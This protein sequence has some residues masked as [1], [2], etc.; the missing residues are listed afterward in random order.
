MG[1]KSV[2]ETER[3]ILRPWRPS[4][5][6]SCFEYASNPLIGQ[7]AGWPPHIGIENTKQVIRDFLMNPDTY[8]ITLKGD[9]RAI[10]SIGLRIG[11][12]L[13][14][15]IAPEEAE[16][17]YWI[18]EPYWGQGLIPEAARALIEYAFTDLNISK[19]WCGYFETNLKSARVSEKLG[20]KYEYTTPPTDPE[21]PARVVTALLRSEAA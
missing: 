1:R 18:G 9:D 5:A 15:E 6:E 14:G 2:I 4:D 19:L 3:L 16:I 7:G 13:F 12:A 11:F 21:S 20:F 10:G 17:G 8:A